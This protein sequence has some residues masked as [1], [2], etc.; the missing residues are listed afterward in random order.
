VKEAVFLAGVM[1][2]LADSNITLSFKCKRQAI[3]SGDN[4]VVTRTD[5]QQRRN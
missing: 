3:N 2:D 1:R 4:T 5:E